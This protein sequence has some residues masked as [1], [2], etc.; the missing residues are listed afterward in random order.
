MLGKYAATIIACYLLVFGVMAALA[1]WLIADGRRLKR[2]L[3]TL[4]ARGVRRR[5]AATSEPD[6][7]PEPNTRS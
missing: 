3:A 7:A 4:E 1:A 6:R 2:Q 5:S